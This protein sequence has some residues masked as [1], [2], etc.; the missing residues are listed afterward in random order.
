MKKAALIL[1]GVIAVII[2][3][4]VI[5]P[6]LIDWNRYKPEIAEAV[7]DATGRNLAI[8]GDIELS[9]L[10]NLE[11]AI[12]DV[13]LSNAPGSTSP[14]MVFID[15]LAGKSHCSAGRSWSITW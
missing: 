2:L 3:A 9:L 14:D 15:N 4:V 1:V 7:K 12:S 10:P 5:V 6:Q 11:F 13:R 8:D